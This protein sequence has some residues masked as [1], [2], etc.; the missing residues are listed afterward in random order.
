MGTITYE[1]VSNIQPSRQSEMAIVMKDEGA[2]FN[3]YESQE[4]G[5]LKGKGSLRGITKKR[6]WK[7][8]P[9]M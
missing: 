2:S 5:S 3:P 6:A 4:V 1:A 7:Q 8:V 9:G